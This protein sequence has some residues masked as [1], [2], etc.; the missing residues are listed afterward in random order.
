MTGP[1][2]SLQ[3]FERGELFF[4]TVISHVVAL[5]NLGLVL[6]IPVLAV[7]ASD[8]EG[9]TPAWVGLSIGIYGLTQS[10]FQIPFGWTSDRIGRRK[11][12]VAGLLIFS[13]GNFV[14]GTAQ[15]VSLLIA[16]RA[17]MGAGA[18]G[19]VCF[20]WISDRIPAERRNRSFGVV[21]VVASLT[22][23]LGFFFGP[24]LYGIFPLSYVFFGC[25][26]LGLLAV[27]VLYGFLPESMPDGS[28]SVAGETASGPSLH[29]IAGNT[30]L[31]L[32]CGMGLLMN[33]FMTSLFFAIPY[34]L[35]GFIEPQAFWKIIT[36]IMVGS[37]LVMIPAMRWA[38]KGRVREVIQCGFAL[39]CLCAVVLLAPPTFFRLVLSLG[40]FVSGY[41]LLAP[42]LPSALARGY[43]SS[44]YGSVMGLYSMFLFFGSFLGA[45]VSGLLYSRGLV[46]IGISLVALGLAGGWMNFRLR[47]FAIVPPGEAGEGADQDSR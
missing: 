10:L 41:V 6:V 17:L 33:Y 24:I 5:R 21:T 29:E 19:S 12:V 16:G 32:H 46:W 42:S 45:T 34:E 13:V 14:A 27:A 20:A 26:L 8:L 30:R 18:I 36:S 25:A 47:G 1:G 23:F 35:K 3:S 22:A 15:H 39:E 31:L 7:F 40:L 11:T 28:R 4:L 37:V 9:S 2:K 38:D 44:H 43:D